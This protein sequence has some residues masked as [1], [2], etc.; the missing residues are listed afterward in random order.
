M[1]FIQATDHSWCTG[2]FEVLFNNFKGQ[3]Q[4]LE[5][6]RLRSVAPACHLEGF[7]PRL[8][9]LTGLWKDSPSAPVKTRRSDLLG[10]GKAGSKRWVSADGLQQHFLKLSGSSPCLELGTEPRL[11]QGNYFVLCKD[12]ISPQR[13]P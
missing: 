2:E 12:L 3:K 1:W 10:N 7:P 4:R 11:A 8:F 13:T 5:S 6:H 9:S